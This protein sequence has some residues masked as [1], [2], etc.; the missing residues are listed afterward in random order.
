MPLSFGY[1]RPN[2][3]FECN[4]QCERCTATS[5]STG[6]RCKLRTCIG[7]PYCWMHLLS[8]HSLRIKPSSIPGA[9]K[10]LFAL[11]RGV[12]DSSEVIFRKRDHITRYGGE[13]IDTAV[14][15]QRYG[16]YTAPYGIKVRNGMYEDAACKRGTGAIAN[17][18]S[19]SRANTRYSVSRDSPPHVSLK[20]TKNIR[21]GTEVVTY[22]GSDYRF[23]ESIQH[24]T[25][26]KK[27]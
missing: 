26:R 11:R 15:N 7:V 9:G 21:N 1:Q 19:R 24:R 23:D 6:Q 14:L 18:A 3:Q 25:V 27:N 8:D 16:S 10:G 13:V 2:G 17:H 12:A 5:K 4:I 20:A 22:Y